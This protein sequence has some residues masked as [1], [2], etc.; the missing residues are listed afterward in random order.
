M[1]CPLPCTRRTLRPSS[2]PYTPGLRRPARLASGSCGRHQCSRIRI[3]RFFFKFKKRDFLR[4]F[5]FVAYV[6]PNN[7]RQ[8]LLH[9]EVYQIASLH[10][11]L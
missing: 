6:L 1:I 2:S 11:E 5:C 3:L 9:L 4:F 7:D 8:S 10:C